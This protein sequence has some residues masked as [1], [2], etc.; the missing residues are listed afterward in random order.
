VWT[1]IYGVILALVGLALLVGGIRLASLDSTPEASATQ[2]TRK[3]D[4]TVLR[5]KANVRTH[6]VKRGDTLYALAKRYGTTVQ[7]LRKLNNL[8]GN[9]LARGKR[10]RVPGTNIRG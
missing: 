5:R 10:L 7:E 3:G 1:R 2:Q 4:V 8:Q 6:T 9:N